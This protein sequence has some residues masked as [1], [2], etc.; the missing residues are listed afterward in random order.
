MILLQSQCQD[1]VIS[2]KELDLCRNELIG[3]QNSNEQLSRSLRNANE[4]IRTFQTQLISE[5]AEN[6]NLRNRIRQLENEKTRIQ[7]ESSR[8]QKESTSKVRYLTYK[9]Q[10]LRS[11]LESCQ[12]N[13]VMFCKR[14]IVRNNGLSLLKKQSEIEVCR[15]Y[16]IYDEPEDSIL[17]FDNDA[18]D[19]NNER[20]FITQGFSTRL[21]GTHE[22]YKIGNKDKTITSF[23]INR[24]VKY[25]L[26]GACG[27]TYKGLVHFFGGWDNDY[28]NQ[29]FGFGEMRKFVKYKNLKI[30]FLRPQCSTFKIMTPNSESCG[31]EVVLLCFDSNHKK[32]CYKYSDGEL[33]HFADANVDHYLARLGKYKDQLITVGDYWSKHEK[34]EILE[35]SNNGEYKWTFGSKYSFTSTRYIYDYSM[36]NVPR[37]GSNEEYLLLIGGKFGGLKREDYSDKVHK[38]NGKWRFFGNLRKTRA[39]HGSV[40]LNGRVLIIGGYE[41]YH[42]RLMKTETW[43]TSKSRFQTESNWPELNDWKS[44]S[45]YVFIIPDYINP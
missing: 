2:R 43:D 42:N 26:K 28:R 24:N 22:K 4:N 25:Q 14:P 8:N 37:M 39:N 31:K 32:N 35:R 20:A 16:G 29:H 27:V 18:K 15:D 7:S 44:Y 33:S 11:S 12:I 17:I 45:N 6:E 41:T 36:V 30:D 3:E 38:Y 5:K 19:G 9:N 10:R 34:T 13:P 21:A 40:F 23:N 1:A